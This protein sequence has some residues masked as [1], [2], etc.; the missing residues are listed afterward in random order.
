[1]GLGEV[2]SLKAKNV[3]G[4]KLVLSEPKS[5]NQIEIVSIPKKRADRL[6]DYEEQ[7]VKNWS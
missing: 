1:M 6:R 3:H 5:G 7:R 4:R 2:L